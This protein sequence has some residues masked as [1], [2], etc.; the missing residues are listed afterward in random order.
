[1]LAPMAPARRRRT[2]I[3]VLAGLAALAGGA[4]LWL[5]I[6]FSGGLGSWLKSLRAPPGTEEID[7]DRVPALAAVRLEHDRLAQLVHVPVPAGA[8]ESVHDVCYE[9]QHNFEIQDPYAHRCTLRVTRYHGLD[10]DFRQQMLDLAG[11]LPSLGWNGGDLDRIVT[12]YLDRNAGT[13]GYGVGDLPSP[14]PYRRAGLSLELRYADR[15]TT[16][17]EPYRYAQVVNFGGASPWR[18][19]EDFVDVPGVVRDATAA[20]RFLLVASIETHYLE[21]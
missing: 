20:H 9:G 6:A 21:D 16:D 8:A 4:V 11:R 14:L 19:R 17:L 2:L 10:G 5:T 1:M 3:A 12:E 18:E 7:R 15:E 13:P